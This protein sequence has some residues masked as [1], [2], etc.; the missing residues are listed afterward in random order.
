MELNDIS[1]AKSSGGTT[2]EDRSQ[3]V[4]VVLPEEQNKIH[5]EQGNASDN[6]QS[7][8]TREIEDERTGFIENTGSNSFH[9]EELITNEEATDHIPKSIEEFNSSVTFLSYKRRSIPNG[10][11]AGGTWGTTKYYGCNTCM[12]CLIYTWSG[13]ECYTFCGLW[14]ICGP[15]GACVACCAPLQVCVRCYP[16]DRRLAYLVNGKVYDR[17]GN[18]SGKEKD[19][20]FQPTVEELVGQTILR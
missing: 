1:H 14:K 13:Y 19:F 20:I 6:M 16:Q 4:Q 12:M 7:N 3:A 17:Y 2:S 18:L 15:L 9:Q 5:N 8:Q 10:C 11:E